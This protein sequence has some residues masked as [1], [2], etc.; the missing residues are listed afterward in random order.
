MCKY[1]YGM[2]IFLWHVF[3]NDNLFQNITIY[4][5]DCLQHVK[6]RIFCR[7]SFPVEAIISGFV[8]C[9]VLKK[10]ILNE[11]VNSNTPSLSY[12]LII[13]LIKV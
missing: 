2:L 12:N 1:F 13:S 4:S 9:T 10:Y 5:C 6:I 8:Y 7:H 3:Q 11:S